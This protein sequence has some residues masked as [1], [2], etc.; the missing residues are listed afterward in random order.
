MKKSIG[1]IEKETEKFFSLSLGITSC[2]ATETETDE[3]TSSQVKEFTKEQA[4]YNWS[5]SQEQRDLAENYDS[6]SKKVEKPKSAKQPNYHM[7]AHVRKTVDEDYYEH[8]DESGNTNMPVC[9]ELSL[10]AAYSMGADAPDELAKQVSAKSG[11]AASQESGALMPVQTELSLDNAYSLGADAP[12]DDLVLERSSLT[13]ASADLV[14]GI[15]AGSAAS[16]GVASESKQFQATQHQQNADKEMQTVARE[17]SDR[18]M[19]T[20]PPPQVIEQDSQTE[21]VELVAG[22]DQEAMTLSFFELKTTW[23]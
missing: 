17:S 4:L 13:S 7:G 15:S 16:S 5:A 6:K 12:D 2:T 22:V 14:K 9:L 8:E 10:D 19:Q 21:K 23:L 20:V 3:G 18:E 1:E 11:S